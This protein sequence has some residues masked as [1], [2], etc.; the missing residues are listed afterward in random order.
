MAG[1]QQRIEP[2]ER[3]AAALSFLYFFCVLAAYY[4][5][6]PVR[7]QLSAAVGSTQLPWFFAATFVATLALTPIFAWLASRWPRRIVVPVVYLFFIACLLAFVPLFTAQ[8]LLSPR[9]LGI[10][11]FVWVS[12]FNLFV[13]SV[14]WSFMSDIW[15][16]QQARRV[17][18]LIATG[19]AIGAITGPVLTSALVGVLGVAPLLVVSVL[20]LCAALGC[21]LLLG[22]WSRRHGANRGDVAHEAAVGGG[23]FDGLRQVFAHPFIRGMALLMVLGDALGTIAYALYV[24]SLGAA[25]ARDV[26]QPSQFH[27]LVVSLY[28]MLPWNDAATLTAAQARTFAAS[29]VDLTTNLL[30]LGMQLTLTRWLLRRYGAGVVIAVW[31]AASVIVLVLLGVLGDISVGWL[32]GLSLAVVVLIVTRSGAYGLVQPARESLYTLVPRELRYKG[33]NAVDTAVWR[34]GDVVV[35]TSMN[36][37]RALG[38]V[39]ATF[40]W[41][42]AL[43]AAASGWVGWALARRAEAGAP[44]NAGRSQRQGAVESDAKPG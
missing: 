6:R 38:A 27:Q 22:R 32:G 35:A 34:A 33:K 12:V 23:M 9:A 39:T 10:V 25:F 1:A 16:E 11:F 3:Q 21:V 37:L 36:G 20:L 4:V 5:I 42:G 13:V 43:A 26:T 24:D 30:Q 15:S 28:G 14:F 41:L 18:P 2:G 17:F 44:G 31:A 29:L 8:G 7:E 19:G 40:G